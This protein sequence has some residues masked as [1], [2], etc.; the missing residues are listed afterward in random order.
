MIELIERARLLLRQE[1][2]NQHLLFE[3]G[4]PEGRGEMGCSI[5]H[6]HVH[7]VGFGSPLPDLSGQVRDLRGE[8]AQGGLRGLS[9]ISGAYSYLELPVGRGFLLARRLPSQTLRKMIAG[10]IGSPRWDWEEVGIEEQLI[11]LVKR[12]GATIAGHG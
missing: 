2:G 6:L 4:D 12:S 3:N 9:G 1:F 10:A 7:L 5:S 11:T 8:A